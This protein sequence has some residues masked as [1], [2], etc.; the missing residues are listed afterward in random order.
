MQHRTL[1]PTLHCDE[2][3]PYIDFSGSPLYL[4]REAQAWEGPRRAGVSSFGFGGVNAHVIVE[5]YEQP[6][7]SAGIRSGADGTFGP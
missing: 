1:A 3:N 7:A 6:A 2:Q 5:E 4:V